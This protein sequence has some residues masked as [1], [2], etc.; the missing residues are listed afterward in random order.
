MMVIKIIRM[1]VMLIV[2]FKMV[3]FVLVSLERYQCVMRNLSQRMFV[4][5]ISLSLRWSSVI[6]EGNLDVGGVL[7]NLGGAVFQFLV[8]LLFV[9]QM[10][11]SQN[12]GTHN[13]ILKVS[14]SAMMVTLKTET[15]AIISAK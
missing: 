15:A 6:M 13:T 5:I 2:L 9:I 1:D 12:A 8:N 10:F 11:R 3:G 4:G 14:N 7:F